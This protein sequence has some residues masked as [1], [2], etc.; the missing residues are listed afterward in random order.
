MCVRV[1]VQVRECACMSSGSRC[2]RRPIPAVSHS[3]AMAV[4]DRIVRRAEEVRCVGTYLGFFEW[5]V[6]GDMSGSHVHMLLGDHVT[7]IRACFAPGLPALVSDDIHRVAGVWSSHG[8]WLS[9]VR[10]GILLP[11]V[12]H[13]V[14]GVAAHGSASAASSSWENAASGS[15]AGSASTVAGAAASSSAGEKAA[16]PVRRPLS[17]KRCAMRVGWILK[18]TEAR[19]NCGID[20]MA[21]H[22]G[23][24]RTAASLSALRAELADAM[25]QR[26]A[27][28]AWH[29]VFLACQEGAGP[30]PSAQSKNQKAGPAKHVGGMGPTAP[31]V[32]APAPAKAA[33]SSP[34]LAKA[35]GLTASAGAPA[36]A[37]SAGTQPVQTA[38][39]LGLPACTKPPGKASAASSLPVGAKA[40]SGLAACGK[41]PEAGAA[42]CSQTQ[43]DHR[44]PLPPPAAHPPALQPPAAEPPAAGPP[45]RMT[46]S[47]WLRSQPEAKV[48]AM[49]ADYFS[50]K[51][52]EAAWLATLPAMNTAQEVAKIRRSSSRVL[53]K[54]AAGASYLV[55]R[56]GSGSQSKAPL[57]DLGPNVSAYG[58]GT[59][60]GERNYCRGNPCGP[61]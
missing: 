17:A 10:D 7:D 8:L 25:L 52:A 26:M 19:G 44:A 40:A 35:S 53:D 48:A 2:C 46:F 34:V 57:Q 50:V 37:A 38:A 32:S 16:G 9:S 11:R 21:H 59:P 23:W 49:T 3:C 54:L 56:A 29:D 14:I 22:G 28:P 18:A 30:P 24:S 33:S 39:A 20:A 31:P 47:A 41:P 51:H 1:Q 45:Q 15:A 5:V 6:W 36:K 43:A 4:V 27:D 13:Y 61:S 55:W 42:S 58:G 12:N 60:R